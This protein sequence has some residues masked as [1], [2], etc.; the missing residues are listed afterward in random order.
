MSSNKKILIATIVPFWELKTGA[1]QRIYSILNALQTDGH[2][3]RVFF[4]ATASDDARQMAMQIG[5]D[6]QFVRPDQRPAS[7][8]RSIWKT[9]AWHV[10]GS[11]HALKKNLWPVRF[12]NSWH[13]D[14]RSGN[15][16]DSDLY[17][18]RRRTTQRLKD[19][20]WAWASTA[21][22]DV[23]AE[24]LPHAIICEYITM[25]YLVQGLPD[26]LRQKTHCLVDTHDLLSY[27]QSQFSQRG[28]THWIDVSPDQET[29]ALNVFD[30]LIAIES[31]EAQQ[32][33]AMVPEKR[34]ILVG[35]DV[36]HSH[37]QKDD[38]HC[39]ANARVACREL[40]VGYLGSRNA[41]NV[42]A[43]ASFLKSVVGRIKSDSK[44]SFVIAGTVCDAISK[45][46]LPP[47]VRMLGPVKH[48][49]DFYHQVDA[50]VNPVEYG[51]GLK[52]KSIEAIA[53]KKPLL[54]TPHG[55]SG[56]PIDGVIVVPRLIDMVDVL[57]RWSDDRAALEEARCGA[58]ASSLA[59]RDTYRPL[60]DLLRELR[61]SP[62]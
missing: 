31:E 40:T 36:T 9:L 18:D 7:V 62:I 53:F 17:P 2:Q 5:V 57:Q 8:N 6:V 15:D 56:S 23:V 25:A 51:T 38:S 11:L 26:C 49:D 52:I 33:R 61:P 46:S 22:N 37:R 13:L 39:R 41:S 47:N 1:H 50:V 10:N 45:T 3:V 54:S 21:F 59:F 16:A 30:T 4:P 44:L 34:V 35:H 58:E 42:D 55:W 28:Q 20:R 19:F 29:E 27:R 24:F 60:L 43:I 32:M 48:V 12:G 14:K